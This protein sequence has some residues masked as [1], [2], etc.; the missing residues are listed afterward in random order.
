MMG[1]E[2]L[3]YTTMAEAFIQKGAKVCIGWNASVSVSHTD[4]ATIK[5]LQHYL[6]EKLTLKQ[7]I[8]ETFKEVGLD[9]TYKSLLV[10]YPP[11]AGEQKIE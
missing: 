7:S 6:I 1:C 11:E 8:Q 2:G 9:P 3:T 4:T 5:L 10:Y